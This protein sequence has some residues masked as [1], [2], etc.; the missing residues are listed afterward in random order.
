MPAKKQI[1][2][3]KILEAAIDIIRKNGANAV[4]ARNIANS[5]KCSTKQP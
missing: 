4:N 5:L 2:K 3:E 1:S